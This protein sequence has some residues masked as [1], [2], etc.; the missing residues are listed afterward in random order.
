M[1]SNGN[2]SHPNG[3]LNGYAKPVTPTEEEATDLERWRLLD[4]RGRQTWHYLQSDR[5][6]ERWPQTA[7]DRYHLGLPTVETSH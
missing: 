7:A 5:E 6:V 2:A 1:A 4:E 3:H